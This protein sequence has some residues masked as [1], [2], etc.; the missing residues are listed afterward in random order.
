MDD[1]GSLEPISDLSVLRFLFITIIEG[2]FYFG[3]FD[4][5][6][7]FNTII[8]TT[9]SLDLSIPSTFNIS[10]FLL[11]SLEILELMP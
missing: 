6:C 11:S 7:L 3:Y 8:G 10:I 2:S 1:F 4:S 5:S 9:G